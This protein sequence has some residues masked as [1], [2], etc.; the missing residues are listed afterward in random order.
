[1]CKSQPGIKVAYLIAEFK[2]KMH[3]C[4]FPNN[5]WIFSVHF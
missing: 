2:V 3:H 1:M 5:Y 4:D